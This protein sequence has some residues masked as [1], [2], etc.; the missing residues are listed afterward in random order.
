VAR[1]DDVLDL[2]GALREAI[3]TGARLLILPS[4]CPRGAS[5]PSP[6][7]AASYLRLDVSDLGGPVLNR[8]T[9]ET[10]RALLERTTRLTP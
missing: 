3:Q 10:G 2:S 6:I 8:I 7:A 4:A 1:L 5:I 9:E